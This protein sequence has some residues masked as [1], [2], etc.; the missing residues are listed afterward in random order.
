M[1]LKCMLFHGTYTK[2]LKLLE[3]CVPKPGSVTEV[4]LWEN[5]VPTSSCHDPSPA[6]RA[7][8]KLAAFRV[9]SRTLKLINSQNF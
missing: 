2:T 3:Y 9:L 7:N 4:K 6:H 1:G 8:K 5:S